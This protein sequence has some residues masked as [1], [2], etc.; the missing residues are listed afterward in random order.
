[1]PRLSSHVDLAAIAPGDLVL[2]SR[3]GRLF[4]ARVRGRERAG[5]LTIE[6]L[7]RSVRDRSA[8]ARD[9]VDHWAHTSGRTQPAPGQLRLDDSRQ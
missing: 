6:P 8:P 7:D 3:A 4:H 9:V 2:V 5:R 1:M